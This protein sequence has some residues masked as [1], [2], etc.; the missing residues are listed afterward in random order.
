MKLALC[1]GIFGA[2]VFIGWW[3]YLGYRQRKQYFESLVR[4]CD[5]LIT[6]IGFSKRTIAQIIGVYID[7]YSPQF[8]TDLLGY[9]RLLERRENLAR[10]KLVLWNGLRSAEK[11]AIG[12]F[13]LE[14]GRH[15]AAEEIE[16]I[17]RFRERFDTSRTEAAEKLKRDASIHLK[18]S[19]LLGIGTV[20]LL[21]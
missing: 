6:E 1:A 12:D 19:I 21:L 9:K 11:H 3:I 5:N 13:F 8:C 10:G 20:I 16:K 14:L 4:F 2:F 15:S 17:R 18:I 7:N